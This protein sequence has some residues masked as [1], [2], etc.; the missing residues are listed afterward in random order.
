M[1]SQLAT[2]CTNQSVAGESVTTVGKHDYGGAEM[3]E[4]VLV[5]RLGEGG[6]SAIPPDLCRRRIQRGGMI[7]LKL[8]IG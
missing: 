3:L 7:I 6:H 2:R 5:D 8:F 1:I 4:G